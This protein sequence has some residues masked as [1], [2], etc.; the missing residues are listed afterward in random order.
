MIRNEK[1]CNPA[2]TREKIT[3]AMEPLDYKRH[4]WPREGYPSPIEIKRPGEREGNKKEESVEC[5]I[6]SYILWEQ[7]T[8]NTKDKDKDIPLRI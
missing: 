7:K 8:R 6:T 1:T 3:L 5:P 2:S 4:L